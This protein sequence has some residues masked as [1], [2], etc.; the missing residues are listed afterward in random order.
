MEAV[1]A[2]FVHSESS[3]HLLLFVDKRPSARE[4]TRQIRQYLNQKSDTHTCE[5]RVIDIV[6]QPYLAEHFRLVATPALIKIHPEPQQVLAGD[7][8]TAQMENW[9]QRWQRSM[10]EYLSTAKSMVSLPPEEPAQLSQ[11]NVSSVAH[12]A[13]LIRLSDELFQ[14]K[15]EKVALEAQLQFKDRLI[16]MLAHDLRNPLTALSIAVETLEMG[17]NQ[18]VRGEPSKISLALKSQLIKHARTQS[19]AIDRM[20]TDIL[21]AARGST[22]QFQIHPVPLDLKELCIDILGRFGQQFDAKS[23]HLKTDIPQDLPQ[24][25]A[26]PDRVQQ[27][28]MNLLDNAIKYTPPGGG[29]QIAALHRTTQKVQISISDDGPGIPYDNQ[30]NIFK[31]RFRLERDEAKDGYGIGLSLCERIVLAHYGKIWVDSAPGQGSS[32]HFTLP[33]YR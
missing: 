4:N 8:I 10:D 31:D 12:E 7:N 2:H 21:Q 29:I 20:I 11:R 19:K 28:M 17:N 32:F 23:Q 27:L 3:I 33:V 26:D 5:L 16:A 15:Q 13:E 24:V 9:W 25:Y 30:E 14:V 6:E 22:A 18:E 1:P